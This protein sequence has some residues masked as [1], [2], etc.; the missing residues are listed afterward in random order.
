MKSLTFTDVPLFRKIIKLVAHSFPEGVVLFP[1]MSLKK[2]V[3]QLTLHSSFR[4]FITRNK[5]FHKMK[6]FVIEKRAAKCIKGFIR[7][8]RITRTLSHL[9]KLLHYNDTIP[10]AMTFFV[11]QKFLNIVKLD[12]KSQKELNLYE[13]ENGGNGNY[14]FKTEKTVS[15]HLL[16]S[17]VINK[18]SSQKIAFSNDKN[19]KENGF[20]NQMKKLLGND[21]NSFN[22]LN[23]NG[24]NDHDQNKLERPSLGDF[25]AS[26]VDPRLRHGFPIKFP[27]VFGFAE[28][29]YVTLPSNDPNPFL[30]NFIPWETIVYPGKSLSM[31]ATFETTIRPALPSMFTEP[32]SKK[33]IRIGRIMRITFSSPEEAFR[34]LFVFAYLTGDTSRFMDDRM[35][36]EYCA[37]LLI[38]NHWR[39][40]L[41][42]RDYR[43][44]GYQKGV[45]VNPSILL[46]QETIEAAPKKEDEPPPTF[47][48]MVRK[49]LP[50]EV[51][52]A[53][54][55]GDYRSWESLH[56]RR[57]IN[58]LYQFNDK[59]YKSTIFP[60]SGAQ[61]VQN[62]E[63][64]LKTESM[65]NLGLVNDLENAFA[66]LSTPDNEGPKYISEEKRRRIEEKKQRK[67]M[68]ELSKTTINGH[69]NEENRKAQ[70]TRTPPSFEVEL[71]SQKI[72]GPSLPR[73]K[74]LDFNVDTSTLKMIEN[75]EKEPIKPIDNSEEAYE[76]LRQFY[77]RPTPSSTAKFRQKNSVDDDQSS[78]ASTEDK[79][80]HFEEDY[81]D[82]EVQPNQTQSSH[83]TSTPRTPSSAGRPRVQFDVL[84]PQTAIQ[85]ERRNK[86][87][88]S[89]PPEPPVT[90]TLNTQ[91]VTTPISKKVT[92][93]VKIDVLSSTAKP[94]KKARPESALIDRSNRPKKIESASRP[95]SRTTTKP[96]KPLIDANS[97]PTV[98]TAII[99]K[100][101]SPQ[102]RV[103]T[104]KLQTVH[105]K[106]HQMKNADFTE[107]LQAP[108]QGS[109]T[110]SSSNTS[111]PSTSAGNRF[112]KSDSVNSILSTSSFLD[113]SSSRQP[114]T[115]TLVPNSSLTDFDS[116]ERPFTSLMITSPQ[117]TDNTMR[118]ALRKAFTK[119]VRLHQLGIQIEQAMI[120]DNTIAEKRNKAVMAREKV[121]RARED[122]KMTKEVELSDL[123]ERNKIEQLEREEKVR[124][125]RAK[126]AMTRNRN[127]NKVRKVHNDAI[128]K[129][130]KE[131]DFALNFVSVSRKIAQ[132]IEQK[133]LKAEKRKDLEEAQSKVQKQ[134]EESKEAIEKYK[135]KVKDMEDY[136]RKIAA[137]DKM[138][139]EEKR[140]LQ[141]EA[142]KRRIELLATIK[143]DEKLMKEAYRA[144]K[145]QKKAIPTNIPQLIEIDEVEGASLIMKDF[146]GPNLGEVESHLLCQ[147]ISE[148]V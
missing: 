80:A 75:M 29:K 103:P 115:A 147:I 100:S 47:K 131:R 134:H 36:I 7:T 25:D 119:L 143:E 38:Q 92:P 127:V 5:E 22:F 84:K 67:N 13:S 93:K 10:E 48:K 102:I 56:R 112:L 30:S 19:G 99:K 125:V 65:K 108:P 126:T 135:Q 79:N 72:F 58:D 52:I 55:R 146:M 95:S 26:D 88:N 117:W 74:E 140:L 124:Q 89:I 148:I 137:R 104:P 9:N 129:Y 132:Q 83:L 133:Q 12:F 6:K 1:P 44:M 45:I 41:H 39:G 8:Q 69:V 118:D 46:K 20:R 31:L 16:H 145:T 35:V 121:V 24:Q 77:N 50:P 97:E 33:T 86:S 37:A 4:M 98:K 141:T 113:L 142:A 59:P 91:K 123:M 111:L 144:S 2:S 82:E 54:L 15:T 61:K 114:G 18:S 76:S 109:S 68:I 57:T 34:R 51:A 122:L 21:P 63:P 87:L 23:E 66:N 139:N 42:R 53:N 62:D 130:K 17:D 90:D 73:V 128:S 85:M 28:E 101:E 110:M 136:K 105:F 94:I 120:I 116:I 27:A 60:D 40:Y 64:E 106:T 32:I 71:E 81:N 3:S 49:E 70:N 138:M 96:P 14:T 78:Q 43:H 107:S 11:S